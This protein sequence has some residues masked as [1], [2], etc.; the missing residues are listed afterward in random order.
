[1]PT[2]PCPVCAKQISDQAPFC[3]GCGHPLKPPRSCVPGWLIGCGC[4]LS[5]FFAFMLTIIIGLLIWLGVSL[6]VPFDEEFDPDVTSS[7]MAFDEKRYQCQANMEEIRLLKEEWAT[8]H[9]A[10]PGSLIPPAEIEKLF[11]EAA[12]KLICP[13]DEDR[14]FKTSYDLGPIGAAPTCKCDDAHNEADADEK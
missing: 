3:P 4:L 11:A 1:M 10:K 9:E 14:S 7:D 2:T 12:Q 8:A 13:K 5:A 6:Q